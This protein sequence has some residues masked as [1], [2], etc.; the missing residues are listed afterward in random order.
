MDTFLDRRSSSIAWDYAPEFG[1]DKAEWDKRLEAYGKTIEKIYGESP[2]AKKGNGA[3]VNALRVAKNANG[4]ILGYRL[5]VYCDGIL[6][7]SKDD[8]KRKAKGT[9]IYFDEKKH[10]IEISDDDRPRLDFAGYFQD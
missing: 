9:S 6:S 10:E 4:K 7:K 2:C 5:D 8:Y 1:V 3:K